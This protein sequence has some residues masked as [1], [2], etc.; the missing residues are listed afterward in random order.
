MRP[1]NFLCL[2]FFDLDFGLIGIAAE[3]KR[4]IFK[5][6]ASGTKGEL[7]RSSISKSTSSFS[8]PIFFREDPGREGVFI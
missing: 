5:V 7:G 8:N 3:I 6:E 2:T 4:S 1:R